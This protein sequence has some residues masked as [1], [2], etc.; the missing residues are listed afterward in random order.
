[1]KR[2]RRTITADT[3]TQNPSELSTEIGY[4]N[5]DILVL[6]KT[7]FELK[8]LSV[9]V[10]EKARYLRFSHWRYDIYCSRYK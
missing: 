6:L 8:G 2:V 9:S 5:A 1:M 4:S 3:E 7:V 10:D